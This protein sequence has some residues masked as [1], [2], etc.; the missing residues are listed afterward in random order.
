[1]SRHRIE[2]WR[3]DIDRRPGVPRIVPATVLARIV[4]AALEAGHA[5]SPASLGL[6]L[7]DDAELAGLN[8]AHMGKD[9]PTDVLSFPLLPPEVFRTGGARGAGGPA[10]A[11]ALPPGR[12]PPALRPAVETAAGKSTKSACAG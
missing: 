9:G 1:M 4:G 5:P 6:I 10:P 3:I 8:W 12:V 11:F 7:T 2:G